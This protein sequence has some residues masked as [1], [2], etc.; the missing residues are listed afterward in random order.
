MPYIAQKDRLILDP[1]INKLSDE[2]VKLS[3]EYNYDGAFAGLLNYSIT[4]LAMRIVNK[5][6]GGLRYWQIAILTGTF[7]NIADE[8]Y[9]MVAVPYENIQINKS[10]NVEEYVTCLDKLQLTTSKV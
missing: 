6:F 10:G 9:R 7:H 8:F 5:Q 1:L 4:S 2:I 3:K